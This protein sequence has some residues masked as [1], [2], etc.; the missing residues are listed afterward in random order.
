M[1]PLTQYF[2][3]IED[4]SFPARQAKESIEFGQKDAFFQ[5]A[6]LKNNRLEALKKQFKNLHPTNLW[7]GPRLSA[8]QFEASD[9][10]TSVLSSD[11]FQFTSTTSFESKIQRLENSIVIVS[12]NDIASQESRNIYS[13][14]AS[15]CSSTCFIAWD[16][17]NHHWLDL[18][19][20]NYTSY[21]TFFI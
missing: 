19:T 13:E 6:L 15:N 17:D 7:L 4:P 18:S 12:N 16:W 1:S 20:F 5:L 2:F 3:S 11:F 21:S 14:L 8:F 10:T 9:L